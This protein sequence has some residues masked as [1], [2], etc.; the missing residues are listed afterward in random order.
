LNN[1]ANWSILYLTEVIKIS[2]MGFHETSRGGGPVV[3]I[4]QMGGRAKA[5]I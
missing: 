1:V 3:P 2:G 5:R 4:G